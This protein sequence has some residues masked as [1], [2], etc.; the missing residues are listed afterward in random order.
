MPV[1]KSRRVPA[2]DA[3]QKSERSSRVLKATKAAPPT[4]TSPA[5]AWV[6]PSDNVE[7]IRPPLRLLSKKQLLDRIDVSFPT[8]WRWMRAGTFPRART[9]GDLKSVWLESEI[10]AWM[11]ALPVRR[12]KDDGA[13][14]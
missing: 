3:A 13:A 10:E 6:P 7:Q 1:S 2:A 4:T 8:I 9:I 12:L 5:D 14:Q 11:A